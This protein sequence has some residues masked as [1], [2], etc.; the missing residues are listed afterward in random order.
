M[1]SCYLWNGLLVGLV[2]VIG[3]LRVFSH[4]SIGSYKDRTPKLDVRTFFDGD[5]EGWGAIFDHSGTQTRSFTLQLKGTWQNDKQGILQEWFE[6]DDGK[7]LERKWDITISDN[8]LFVGT[9]ADVIGLAHGFQMGNAINMHYTLRIP[10]KKGSTMNF[11]MD[12]WLYEVS[13]GVIL[14]R[15]RMKK[16]GFPVGELVLMMK[17]K[18]QGNVNRSTISSPFLKAKMKSFE[19]IDYDA[20]WVWIAEKD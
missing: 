16:F 9:A 15:A 17:K 19:L 10:Y 6:L 7:K 4:K 1:N 5:I 18:V 12:D 3:L 8:T 14:N 13:P 11:T 2:V 20:G